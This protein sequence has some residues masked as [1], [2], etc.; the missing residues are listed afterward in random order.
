MQNP[1]GFA[2]QS[3][4]YPSGAGGYCGNNEK[5]HYSEHEASS[6]SGAD[7]A[8]RIRQKW[9]MASGCDRMASVA[10]IAVIDLMMIVS[11]Q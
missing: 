11:A 10:V 9:I 4:C 3:A 7:T 1:R 6:G 5:E 2:P 8:K